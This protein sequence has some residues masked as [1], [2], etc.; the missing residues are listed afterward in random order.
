MK[1]YSKRINNLKDYLKSKRSKLI[2]FD[3]KHIQNLNLNVL[4]V[5]VLDK[6]IKTYGNYYQLTLYEYVS[7]AVKEIE[8][9][10]PILNL[11]I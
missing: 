1:D 7:G 5:I 8:Y 9:G 2:N 11:M 6:E 10:I 3:D 4:N